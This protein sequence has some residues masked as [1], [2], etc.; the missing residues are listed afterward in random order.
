MVTRY[1]DEKGRENLSEPIPFNIHEKDKAI[2]RQ[3]IVNA[4]ITAPL[5]IRFV[6]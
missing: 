1:W 5:P 6:V 3:N 2:I 4:V